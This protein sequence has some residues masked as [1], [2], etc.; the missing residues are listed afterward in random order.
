MT[1][2]IG[3]LC[4]TARV[5]HGSHVLPSWRQAMMVTF[6]RI[7]TGRSDCAVPVRLD[8]DALFSGRI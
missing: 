4:Y 3:D 1:T 2:G 7:L 5:M 6:A 8:D